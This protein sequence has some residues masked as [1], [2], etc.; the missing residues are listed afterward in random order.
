MRTLNELKSFAREAAGV[1]AREK[2]LAS[3][4]V[5]C[6]STEQLV[7]RLNYTSDI[8]CGGVEEV[9][10][11]SADGFAIRI[12]SA[13]NRHENS[14]AFEAGDLSR[15][16]VRAALFRARR[17]MVIDPHF[18]GLPAQ[19]RRL[20]LAAAGASDLHRVGNAPLVAAAWQIVR[21]AAAAFGKN[22]QSIL[23]SPGLIVG[24]DVS[25]IRDR[26][27]L[28]S[29]NFQDLRAD[30]SAHFTS[31]V[32]VLVE[33]LDAKGTATAIGGSL[34]ELR[35][36]APPLGRDAV[37]RAI[38]LQQGER[39]AAGEYRVLFGSQPIAEI[40]NYMVMGSLTTGAFHAASSA[41]QGRFGDRVMDP[42][43]SLSDDPALARGAVARRVTCEGLPA[44]RTE[45]V[46]DGHLIGLLSNFYDAHRLATDENRN[47]KLGPHANGAITFPA[48][49]GYRLGEGGGRRFDAGPGAAGTNVVMRARGGLDQR[50]LLKAVGD[51]IYV[52]RVWYT[53]PIN[54]Q[55]AGQFTCTVSG[56]SYLIRNGEIAA[57][58]AP[59]SVRIN[60]H[61]DQVFGSIV[62]AGKRLD[63]ALVWGSPEVY[64]VP[65]IVADRIPLAPVGVD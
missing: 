46:R 4:E 44:G 8:P 15:D 56:D 13:N 65:A 50:A 25:L 17:A 62:A 64:Y 27:A 2:D 61:I 31:S 57:P 10:S 3:F 22:S 39:P 29:S 24:G 6:S 42:R 36:L 40:L 43:L 48:R 1:V 54:G 47:E 45:L 19:P 20:S 63:A 12:M 53:Y 55:R 52:G 51:G 30:Q 14:I 49:S 37:E 34:A 35:R 59:N 32:T 18:P 23:A 41:Y 33:A 7:A 5:Y 38:G 11:L 16:G 21:N 60:A 58:L 9:K 28:A 26:I